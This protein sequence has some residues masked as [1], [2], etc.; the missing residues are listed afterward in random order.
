MCIDYYYYYSR[1]SKNEPCTFERCLVQFLNSM[2]HVSDKLCQSDF[3]IAP[4][5]RYMI[6]GSESGETGCRFFVRKQFIGE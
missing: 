3:M 1:Y 2:S 6:Y 5:I 4:I